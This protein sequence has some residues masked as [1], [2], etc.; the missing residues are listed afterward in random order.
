MTRK[1][2]PSPR[3]LIR[4]LPLYGLG[5]LFAGAAFLLIVALVAR[6]IGTLSFIAGF[7]TGATGVYGLL[8][9]RA[10]KHP[11]WEHIIHPDH[12]SA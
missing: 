4:L 1:P 2:F 9:G 5:A 8:A 10:S 3:Y 6:P 11:W 7:I 12:Q